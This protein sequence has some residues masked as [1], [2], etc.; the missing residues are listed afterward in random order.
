MNVLPMVNKALCLFQ[1]RQALPEAEAICREA[2]EIDPTCDI[3]VATLGQL[4]LQQ[5][6]VHEAVKAFEKSAE[7]ARTEPELVNALAFE[8]ATKA[9]LDFIDKYPEV[10]SQIWGYHKPIRVTYG[11]LIYSTHTEWAWHSQGCNGTI[12][13]KSRE[14]PSIRAMGKRVRRSDG[15]CSY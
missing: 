2:L 3:A 11:L 4:L 5:N 6:K 8:N 12:R 10:R 13:N 1:S 9:Q 14:Q 7:I 15:L